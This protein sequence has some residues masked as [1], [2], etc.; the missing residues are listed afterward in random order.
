[1]KQE[2]A[3][4]EL[5]EAFIGEITQPWELLDRESWLFRYIK[6]RRL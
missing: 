1:M 2:I 4:K 5:G 6:K 3:R